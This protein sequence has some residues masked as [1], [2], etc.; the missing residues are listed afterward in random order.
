MIIETRPAVS[1]RS[2]LMAAIRVA[3]QNTVAS[4]GPAASLDRSER[5]DSAGKLAWAAKLVDGLL[6]ARELV[7]V[8]VTGDDL[9]AG[10]AGPLDVRFRLWVI[11]D[12]VQEHH[13][14]R[15]AVIRRI[16]LVLV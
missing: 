15:R 7:A 9:G 8:V 11:V 13:R 14:R 5:P 1:L 12:G 3:R 6:N 2:K 4:R 10:P 16:E